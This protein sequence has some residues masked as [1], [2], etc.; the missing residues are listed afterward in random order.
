MHIQKRIK[1]TILGT[2]LHSLN[3]CKHQIKWNGILGC[4]C[5]MATFRTARSVMCTQTLITKES[6]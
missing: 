1:R 4:F 6:Y 3:S 2:R 5:E